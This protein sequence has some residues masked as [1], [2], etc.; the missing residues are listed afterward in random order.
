MPEILLPRLSD[1]VAA[2]MGLHFPMERW[3]DLERGIHSAARDFGFTDAE[4]CIQW[5]LASPLTRSQVEVLASHLTVGETYF[6]REKRTFALLEE[7]ILPELIRS[8]RGMNQHLRIWSAGCASG[9]EPYSIAILLQKLIPDVERWNITILAT[10]INPRFLQKASQGIYADWSFRDTPLWVRE[11]YFKK[12]EECRFRIL[13]SIQKMVSFSHL[14]LAEDAYPSLCNNTNAMDVIFCRNVL[15]YFAAEWQKQVV[16][17]FHRSLVEG[18]W[19]LVSPVETSHVLFPQFVPVNFPSAILYRKDGDKAPSLDVFPSYVHEEPTPWLPPIAFP[20]PESEPTP[21]IFPEFSDSLPV[22]VGESPKEDVQVSPYQE[23]LT[24]Y[25]L[26]RYSGAAENLALWL[27]Q[28]QNDNHAMELLARVY[29]NLGQLAEALEWCGRAI[30]ADKVNVGCHYLRAMILQEQGAVEEA[31]KS[32]QR[33]LYLDSKFVLA[34]FGLGN[35]ALRQG[36]AKE[37]EK[38]LEN[39]LS[40][41]RAFRQE[42][43]LPESEGITAGRLMEIIRSTVYR[44]ALA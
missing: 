40:L 12:T 38:H 14:N 7:H 11:G 41:L 27:S 4:A 1:F 44:E 39:A 13:P 9:E 18:G 42:D 21:A 19:L 31:T 15:M 34:H 6:F 2:Q 10:D 28:N 32:L 23:A 16:D 20:V 8:R 35:L 17:N 26:G 37:A 30:A 3:R 33:T 43:T 25:Q 36:K 24:L 29:A 5:L 22:P